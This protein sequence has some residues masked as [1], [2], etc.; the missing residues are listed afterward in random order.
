M[1]ITNVLVK[2]VEKENSNVKGIATVTIDEVFAIHNIYIIDGKKGMF[3]AMPSRKTATG[4]FKDVCHPL[5]QETRD[6]FKD[7]I[8]NEYNKENEQDE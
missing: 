2:K 8:L 6:M 3:I 1:K 7:A 5:N 4:E